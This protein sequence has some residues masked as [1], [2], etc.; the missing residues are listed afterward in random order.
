[1]QALVFRTETDQTSKG[2]LTFLCFDR[3]VHFSSNWQAD[4]QESLYS[5]FGQCDGSCVDRENVVVRELPESIMMVIRA[6][7]SERKIV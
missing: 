7:M 1:M 3:K 6:Y 2:H 4:R 5:S